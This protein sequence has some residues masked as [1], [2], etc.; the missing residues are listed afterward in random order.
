VA[1]TVPPTNLNETVW[2]RAAWYEM[3]ALTP[4]TK[5]MGRSP[6]SI[7]QVKEELQA[8]AGSII[9]FGLVM[10]AQG[11][12]V[13]AD[14][15]LIGNEEQMVVYD[16][17]VTIS[18]FRNGIRLPGRMARQKTK[19]DYYKMAKTQLA[20][21]NADVLEE[22]VVR[23]FCGDTSVSFGES[24]AAC[25]NIIYGGDATSD[26]DMDS[27]DWL[28]TAELERLKEKAIINDPQIKPIRAGDAGQEYYAVIMHP[29]VFA[30]LRSKDTNLRT[31]WERGQERGDT[32]PLFKPAQLIWNG[33]II[34]VSK[35][36]TAPASNCRRSVLLGAQAG[37]FAVGEKPFW[38]EDHS[39]MYADYDNTPGIATGRVCG[40][41][42]TQFNSADFGVYAIDT[43]C[44]STGLAGVAH[45]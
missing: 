16:E 7:I 23:S 20:K 24:G 41:L 30:Y 44:P 39:S 10:N 21:W 13:T 37:V 6:N 25:T 17:S 38:K 28:G 4:I 22:N 14:N 5:L 15:T 33:M 8:T 31:A 42:K 29:S 19:L 2:A 12:P 18:Q 40:F 26:G 35:H 36:C 32:N 45:S 9:R 11:S 34:Y 3:E 27:T 1:V 43:W